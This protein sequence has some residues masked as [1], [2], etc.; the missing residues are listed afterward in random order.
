MLMPPPLPPSHEL[1]AQHTGDRSATGPSRAAP[2]QQSFEDV[3]VCS[4]FPEGSGQGSQGA[5]PSRSREW[6]KEQV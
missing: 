6:G 3:V 5:C 4:R 2:I 1:E